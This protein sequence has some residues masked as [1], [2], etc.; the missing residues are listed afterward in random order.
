LSSGSYDLV[1]VRIDDGL[2]VL[3]EAGTVTATA[4]PI[5]TFHWD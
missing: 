1:E 4:V 3:L 2:I 5:V